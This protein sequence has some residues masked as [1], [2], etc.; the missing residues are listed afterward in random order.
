MSKFAA[1]NIDLKALGQ[2]KHSYTYTLDDEYFGKIDST[3]VQ[4][5][6]VTA[7]VDVMVSA[8]GYEVKFQVEGTAIIACD[9][10]LDDMVQAI[11]A[12]D[13]LRIR[14]GDELTDDGEVMVLPERDPVL[15]VAWFLYELIALA[16][17]I[18]HVHAPGECNK[19]MAAKLRSHIAVSL[20]DEGDE[21]DED[22]EF[23]EE[24]D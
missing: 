14:L 12:D 6:N 4:R 9:R 7:V 13:K 17:P 23:Y 11:K 18:K 2:G 3:E 21:E 20:N 5:G 19:T 1:Y 22:S 15:N 24:E 8:A 16:I 10:C